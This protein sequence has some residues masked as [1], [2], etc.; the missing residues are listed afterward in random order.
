MNNTI[1]ARPKLK[2][3]FGGLV[4][5]GLAT[6]LFFARSRGGV[7]E[8]LEMPAVLDDS[9]PAEQ[10]D[11]R[12]LGILRSTTKDPNPT[13][14]HGEVAL[15][16][17]TAPKDTTHI[18]IQLPRVDVDTRMRGLQAT[19]TTSTGNHVVLPWQLGSRDDRIVDVMVLPG[20]PDDVR[21]MD[22]TVRTAIMPA[23]TWR[24]LRLPRPHRYVTGPATES[25][26]EDDL[27]ISGNARIIRSPATGVEVDL[28]LAGKT[29]NI[30]GVTFKGAQFEWTG[31]GDQPWGKDVVY[32][33]PKSAQTVI[34]L[35]FPMA[36]QNR[37]VRVPVAV[38]AYRPERQVVTIPQVV[39]SVKM[40]TFDKR[41]YPA[42][43]LRQKF[44]PLA[45]SDSL[46]VGLALSTRATGRKP[47]EVDDQYLMPTVV[48]AANGQ[49]YFERVYRIVPTWQAKLIGSD[50]ISQKNMAL[51]RQAVAKHQAISVPLGDFRVEVTHV[52][53]LF[54]R[55][56]SLTLPLQATAGAT[57]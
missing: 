11:G 39:L 26:K 53:P 10:A 6:G 41:T 5:T 33:G 56:C 40:E 21:W 13:L 29:A 3:A 4:L 15:V 57:K 16:A 31:I 27:T 50:V 23:H 44:Q 1:S 52:I 20:Y 32:P 55:E 17:A 18:W 14:P 30:Y 7:S 36:D 46:N 28:R 51:L 25:V 42:I 45:G 19:G 48:M 34:S 47:T 37:W 2:L 8:M 24:V 22:V 12:V 54:E 9:T 49:S 43:F 38:K 35:P